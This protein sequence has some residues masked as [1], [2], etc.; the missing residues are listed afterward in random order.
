MTKTHYTVAEA[1]AKI[2]KN[3]TTVDRHLKAGKLSFELNSEGTKVIE[4]SELARAYDLKPEDLVDDTPAAKK[5]SKQSSNKDVE[6]L[7][8][9]MREHY[10]SRIAHLEKT[11][12][13]ALDITPLLEDRSSQQDQW[14]KSLD[15]M[16]QQIAQQTETQLSAMQTKHDQELKK[17]K[18]AL[19]KERNKSTWQKLFG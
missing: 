8:Q 16:A 18:H 3:R 1:A 13:K 17:L 15:A 9:Q 2:G 6:R 14:Q 4:A 5:E 10:E 11:L 19:H 7:Q 12:D